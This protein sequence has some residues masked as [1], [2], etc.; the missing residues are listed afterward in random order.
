MADES[1]KFVINV[2]YKVSNKKLKK[3]IAKEVDKKSK[4]KQTKNKQTADKIISQAKSKNTTQQSPITPHENQREGGAFGKVDSGAKGF[5]DR[6]GLGGGVEKQQDSISKAPFQKDMYMD[7]LKK[8]KEKVKQLTDNQ[9]PQAKIKQAKIKKSKSQTPQYT[10][11]RS[12]IASHQN[13][14]RGGIYGRVDPKVKGF[15]GRKGI[16]GGVTKAREDRS[17]A[18]FRQDRYIVEMKK[19][20]ERIRQNTISSAAIEKIIINHMGKLV[21][22]S[23]ILSNP[24]G[25]I[26]GQVVKAL[27]GSGPHGAAIVAG[28]TAIFL[29]PEVAEQMIKLFSQKGLP[30]NRDW[31]EIVE[32]Q[33]NGLF[34]IE[35]K[36]KRLLGIDSYIVSQTD[37]Y[38]PES[39]STTRNS[40]ENID[41][42]IISKS[43]LAEKAVGVDY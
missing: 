40:F 8:L 11:S 20:D 25:A 30:L 21:S 18:P 33:V 29:L 10:G 19:R 27:G 35:D 14:T 42:S 12:P 38:S 26:G 23:Q 6:Q 4:N 24:Q 15:Q 9:K 7:E 41:E 28:I 22:G 5:Q 16:W 32:D 43:G 13:Q 2:E 17:K 37:S 36:K 34:N 31:E 3:Q 1:V 39:G